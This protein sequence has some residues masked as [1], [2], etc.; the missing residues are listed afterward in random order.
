MI[1]RLTRRVR[2]CE[3]KVIRPRVA[4]VRQPSS[5]SSSSSLSS[6]LSSSRLV[7]PRLEGHAIGSPLTW[8]TVRSRRYATRLLP[9]FTATFDE[10]TMRLGDLIANWNTNA[11]GFLNV[12]SVST[13]LSLYVQIEARASAS[14]L[15]KHLFSICSFL[16]PYSLSC[17]S[18]FCSCLYSKV[19]ARRSLILWRTMV[20]KMVP[21]SLLCFERIDENISQYF[22]SF[23][24]IEIHLKSYTFIYIKLYI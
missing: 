17:V 23:K 3:C 14:M 24:Y 10:S 4:F 12:H 21:I 13:H 11:S 5:S 20:R 16:P 8:P 1:E 9:R 7:Q 6:S 22:L 19:D 18:L 2:Q 15:L